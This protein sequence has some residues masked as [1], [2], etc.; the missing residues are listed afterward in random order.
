MKLHSH[1]VRNVVLSQL[2]LFSPFCGLVSA[3]Q[4]DN[5]V[6]VTQSVR[7]TGKITDADGKP[8]AGVSVQ[9]KGGEVVAISNDE[10]LYSANV[11]GNAVL[12]FTSLGFAGNQ[13]PVNNQRVLNTVMGSTQKSL[14]EVVVVGYG[15]QR[16]RAVTGSVVSVGYDQFKDRS[17]SNV[18]QSLEGTVAGVNITTTQG[19][20][21]FGPSIRIRGI[22]SITAGTTPLYVVDG[23]AMENFDLNLIN[24]QDIQSIDILKDAASSAIYGSRGANGVILVTTKLGKAGKAQVNVTIEHGLQEVTRRVKV[25]NAQEWIRYYIDARN[26]AWIARGGKASDPNSARVQSKTYL[27]PPEFLTNPGQFGNGTD[28]QDVVFRTART[29]NVQ[30]SVSGGTDKT[31]YLFSAGYLDQ[32]A[33]VIDNFYKRLSLRT[34][35]RQKISD[36]LAVGMNLSLTGTNDRT[37]GTTGKSDVISLAIQ[38]DPIFPLY[39]ENG[40]L[41]FLDPNSTWNR[42]SSYGVQLWHPYSLIKFANKINK[43][44]NSIASGYLEYKPFQ[45]LTFR[46]SINGTLTNRNYSWFWQTNQGYGYSNLL[47]AQATYN[48]YTNTN[49]MT[50]NTLAYDKKIGEHTVGA[51]V[52]YSAQKQRGDSSVQGSTNFPND[53]VETLNAAGTFTQSGTTTGQ[54]SLLSWLGRVSYSYKNRYFVNGTIRRDGSSRFGP[55]TRWGYFPSIAGGW[56]IS[57]EKFMENARVVNNLKLRVSYGVTGNNQIPNYGPVSLLGGSRYA[58]GDNVVN[59]L[60]VITIPNPNLRWEK[61]NQ[62][63]VGVDLAILNNR[64]NVT[65]EYYNSVTR[66]LL[67]NV[68]VPITTGFGTQLTNIGKVR[69]RGVELTISTKNIHGPAFRWSTDFNISANRNKV[70]Q[71][72][73]GNAPVIAED[74]GRFV[75]EV[76]QP[77]S[78]YVGYIFDGVYNNQKQIDEGPRYPSGI[79]VT[80][81]DPIVRD[82]DGNGKIDAND[83]TYIGNAQPDYIGGLTNTFSYKNFEFAFML[84]GT[85]GNEILNQQSRFSKFWN[86][87]R[88]SYAVVNNYWKSEQEPGD[89]QIFK[90]NAE[91][92]GLQTQFSSYWIEDGSFVRIKNVRLSYAIPQKITAKTPFRGARLYVNAENVY[93]FSDYLGYDPEN[94]TYSTGTDASTSNG[95]TPGLQVGADYGGYPIPLTVTFGIKLDF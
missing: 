4:K 29:N 84:Q 65:A 64:V 31:Q 58:Y 32:D 72:G 76:G 88:N 21:G 44:Y 41:G 16:K 7:I 10:G 54:W 71:L 27:I 67:L 90:P 56:L 8:V 60:R 17:F 69:N 50:E 23:M 70:L 85:F 24:P 48:T 46:S 93:V 39:N 37:D 68:P 61:T 52:G 6:T 34:N 49:W 73:P 20:P 13:V 80:P 45:D 2:L 89:G 18:A 83:R 40:N 19:A 78:N 11:P 53:L 75:T 30:M 95:S 1:F 25:M 82:V 36:K 92:K 87:S 81:G 57:D 79:L 14:E 3:Q 74:W 26:N 15:T 66:D 62:F 28:W 12:V 22:T 91:Y 43:T 47:P 42:F 59:G 94:S 55:N 51:I 86:D 9:V 63:N 35:I 33:V 38:S 5:P 77:I